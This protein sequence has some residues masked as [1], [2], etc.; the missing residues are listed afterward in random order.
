MERSGQIH[1]M[2]SI[3]LEFSRMK[4]ETD[5]GTKLTSRHDVI[6]LIQRCTG[7]AVADATCALARALHAHQIG[8]EDSAT[9]NIATDQMV[10]L[11]NLYYRARA[12]GLSQDEFKKTA[13]HHGTIVLRKRL[14]PEAS[15]EVLGEMISWPLEL[16][17]R[18]LI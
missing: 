9:N 4:N 13:R 10:R 18:A 2:R 12:T 17:R 7:A 14:G 3:A 15:D 5:A 6:D 8:S 11:Q 1:Q 16:L